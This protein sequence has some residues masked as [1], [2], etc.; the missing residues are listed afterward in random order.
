[1]LSSRLMKN[2]MP[3][4]YKIVLFEIILQKS[5]GKIST[6]KTF[7]FDFNL[8]NCIIFVKTVSTLENIIKFA[9][10]FFKSSSHIQYLLK[11]LQLCG[12]TFHVGKLF[13]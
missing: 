6:F 13:K 1:M 11:Y 5:I 2:L 10:S 8:K 7:T 9:Q 12:T 3:K 4:L